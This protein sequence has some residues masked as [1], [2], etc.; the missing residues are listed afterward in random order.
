VRH[1]DH[2]CP[3]KCSVEVVDHLGFLGSQHDCLR[4][5]TEPAHATR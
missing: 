1:D 3:V 5:L 2:T 4:T